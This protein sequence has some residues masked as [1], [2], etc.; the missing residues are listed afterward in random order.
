MGE[1]RVGAGFVS[2]CGAVSLSAFAGLQA[3]SAQAC[4]ACLL[5]DFHAVC[6]SVLVNRTQLSQ[7]FLLPLAGFGCSDRHR[8]ILA[9]TVFPLPGISGAVVGLGDVRPGIYGVLGGLP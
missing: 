8:R 2:F 7:I 6:R 3:Q 4:L 1:D 5:A 9:G